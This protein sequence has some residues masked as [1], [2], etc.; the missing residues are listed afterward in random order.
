MNKE[1]YDLIVHQHMIVN[2]LRKLGYLL[3]F[4][5]MDS[6]ESGNDLDCNI[7]SVLDYC[8]ENEEVIIAG[9]SIA[10]LV[11][12]V[13]ALRPCLNR[14][15]P[16]PG[17]N[18]LVFMIVI[19]LFFVLLIT[20][21]CCIL[22][23]RR[24][25]MQKS[26]LDEFKLR[27]HHRFGNI[28]AFPQKLAVVSNTYKELKTAANRQR[29]SSL[30][31]DQSNLFIEARSIGAGAF[32]RVYKGI[33]QNYR[34]S[35]PRSREEQIEVA[36]KKLPRGATDLNKLD[37]FKEMYIMRLINGHPNILS[38]LGSVSN[39]TDPMIVTEYCQN[40]DL[41]HFIRYHCKS[42]EEHIGSFHLVHR[43]LAARN[44]FINQ[45]MVAK[46]GDFGLCC[47]DD[48][49]KRKLP[50]KLAIKWT[51]IEALRDGTFSAKSDVWSFGVVLFEIF[52]WGRTPY[53]TTQ[54]ENM[55]ETLESGQRLVIDN[56]TL[57]FNMS[58]FFKSFEYI[59]SRAGIPTPPIPRIPENTWLF[60]NL[61]DTKT[62]LFSL[63]ANPN[64]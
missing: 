16:I 32:G 31:I 40:G 50:D 27:E 45:N 61:E 35:N 11:E 25:Q 36:V 62:Q 6:G 64:Q 30:E 60:Q 14:I 54:A 28:K 10:T 8:T 2:Q 41:L 57:P 53:P 42:H 22:L 21:S 13:E 56:E 44:I 3:K 17:P 18:Y 37:L 26:L 47:R 9:G 58:V 63:N 38:L 7:K 20:I 12:Y 43:D 19:P 49:V 24:R 59:N 39:T 15:S 34:Q 46:I 33:L 48:G 52:T 29:K 23:L 55:L 4:I 1:V 51:A 5:Y